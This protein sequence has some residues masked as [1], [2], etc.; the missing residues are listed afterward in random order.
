MVILENGMGILLFV[1]LILGTTMLNI[2]SYLKK[3]PPGGFFETQFRVKISTLTTGSSILLFGA[4]SIIWTA[5][6]PISFGK[7]VQFLAQITSIQIIAEAISISVMWIFRGY[8]SP[9]MKL[10]KKA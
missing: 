4:M 10:Q 5:I 9:L 8:K 1:V 7:N 2:N 3:I 6:D